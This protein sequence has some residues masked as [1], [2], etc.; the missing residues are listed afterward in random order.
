VENWF[1]TRKVVRSNYEK[2]AVGLSDSGSP[3]SGCNWG[4]SG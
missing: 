3:D 4:G 1:N 2:V